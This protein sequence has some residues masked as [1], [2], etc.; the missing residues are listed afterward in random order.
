MNVRNVRWIG[1]GTDR[2]EEMVTFLRDV[3]GLPTNFEEATTV[4]FSTSEGDQV[5]VMGPGDPY[6]DLFG[7]HATGPVPLFE[8]DDV[9]GAREELVAAGIE[10]VGPSGQDRHWDWFHFRAPDGNLYELAS[11]RRT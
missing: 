6:H 4:E 3:L 10:I 9:A 11:R 2:F 5:Q 8:V 7:E 1:I